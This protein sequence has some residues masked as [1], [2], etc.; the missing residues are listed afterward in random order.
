MEGVEALEGAFKLLDTDSKGTRKGGLDSLQPL[1]AALGVVLEARM[2]R[3]AKSS[4]RFDWLAADCRLRDFS[5]HPSPY[6]SPSP[7]H[8]PLRP[9]DT[10]RPRLVRC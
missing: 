3:P 2:A 5:K 4:V 10:P 1:G 7:C 9:L 6:P 8:V